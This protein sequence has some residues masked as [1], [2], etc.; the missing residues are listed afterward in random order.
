[1]GNAF[2]CASAAGITEILTKSL[3]WRQR[4]QQRD[5]MIFHLPYSPDVS[6]KGWISSRKPSVD[7]DILHPATNV[8]N[9][10][11]VDPNDV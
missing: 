6:P 1:M 11:E 9:K 7:C 2:I 4:H 5:E 3:G 10:P 8:S